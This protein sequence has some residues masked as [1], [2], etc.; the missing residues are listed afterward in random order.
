M[1]AALLDK[2]NRI[3]VIDDDIDLLML[4]E[5]RLTKEG[6]IVETAASLPEAEEIISYFEPGLVLLDIN[7]NGQDGRQLC[8]KVKYSQH[9]AGVKVIIMSGY[10]LSTGRSLLFGADEFI[11][12]PLNM[13]FLLTRIDKHLTEA[14]LS[15]TNGAQR[16]DRSSMDF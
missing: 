15:K 5:R 2:S 6:Y 16:S 1:C 9:H 8:Y 12:K 10:D 7:L 3:L 13:D 4:V 14:V 11:A